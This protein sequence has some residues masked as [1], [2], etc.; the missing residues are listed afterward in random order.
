MQL[1]TE[2]TAPQQNT[3]PSLSQPGAKRGLLFVLS[4]PSGTGKDTVIN[5][6][7]AQG[8]DFHVV[9]SVTTRAPRPG[10]SE[11]NPYYFVSKETFDH[12]LTHDELLEHAN[13]HGNWYGQPLQPIRDN[14]NAGRD[15]LLK[16]DVQGAA[17]VRKK[18][19]GATFIFLV[20]GSV[21]ELV[22]RLNIRQTETESEVRRRLMDAQNE[23]A[24]RD[25]YDYI[26][27]NRQGQ[28]QEA[29]E[30]LRAIILAEHCR[31]HP[32]YVNI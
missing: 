10:E 28:L 24:Q 30:R 2:P 4:A 13:V 5:A 25:H 20:P 7:R 18:L 3:S 21:E 22:T 14:L 17:T 19:P 16:I 31:T 29:V 32:R 9:A 15:V 11:G 6:L 26:I 12:M 23:L 8:M 1:E 27:V